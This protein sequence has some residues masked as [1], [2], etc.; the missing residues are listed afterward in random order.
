MRRRRQGF[1]S[2]LREVSPWG[3]GFRDATPIRMENQAQT[4]QKRKQNMKWTLGLCCGPLE[5]RVLAEVPLGKLVRVLVHC[6][7]AK[8]NM[9][10]TLSIW[11]G[12]LSLNPKP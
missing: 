9:R 7:S 4:K 3:L 1:E 10:D 12:F 2:R 8:E 5:I 11:P 6:R